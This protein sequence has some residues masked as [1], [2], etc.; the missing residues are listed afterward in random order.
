VKV[1]YKGSGTVDEKH[2]ILVFLFDS[3]EFGHSNVMPFALMST[4][5]K[6]GTVTFSDVA[7]SPAYVGAL[8]E[9]SGSYAERQGPPPSGSSLGMYSKTPGQPTPVKVEAGKTA[10]VEF[11]FDDTVKMHSTIN[12]PCSRRRGLPTTPGNRTETAQG[13]R[14]RPL[15]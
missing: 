5:S 14:F 10:N 13:P 8:Y 12:L 2:K 9:P 6:D 3:P 15:I 1:H 7:K 11:T 4:S